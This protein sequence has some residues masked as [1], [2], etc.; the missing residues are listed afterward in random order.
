MRREEPVRT[1]TQQETLLSGLN[2]GHWILLM[3]G[4]E[5]YEEVTVEISPSA[6]ALPELLL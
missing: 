4:L 2:T 1:M 6:V 5:G 3:D